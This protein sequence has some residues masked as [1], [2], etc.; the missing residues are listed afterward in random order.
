MAKEACDK[1][2]V[3]VVM[4]R[5]DAA[6]EGGALFSE[7]AEA[8]AGKAPTM[9][10]PDPDDLAVIMYTSGTTGNPKGVMQTHRNIC[11]M[12][13]GQE[14]QGVMMGEIM[15]RL[16]APP[17][18]HEPCALLPVPLFHVVALHHVFLA[19]VT[20]GQKLVMMRRWDAKKALEHIQNEKVVR[21]VG[22][23]TMVTD[24]MEHPEF[25]S[26]DTS[27]LS[28]MVSGG[29]PT[30]KSQV[31]RTKEALPSVGGTGTGQGYGLTETN[32]GVC[33]NVGNDYVT[34]PTSTGKPS[35]WVE[36]EIREVEKRTTDPQ[37]QLIARAE[38]DGNDKEE[39]STTSA[40]LFKLIEKDGTGEIAAVEWQRIFP[41]IDEKN[42]AA[43]SKSE[44]AA[45]FMTFKPWAKALPA[46][47]Q[48][49]AY[50]RSPTNMPGY[51]NKPEQ[52]AEVLDAEGWFASGDIAMLDD[53]GCLYI[54]DR[55][56]DLIIRGG[57]NISCVEVEAAH[58]A[59]LSVL[60]P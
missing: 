15:K 21:F 51:F 25:A 60:E 11:V 4:V 27:S 41:K 57:E 50:I 36:L 7:S 39:A 20:S 42:L 58:P 16:G 45:F 30:P 37:G 2:G 18:K 40:T 52:T 48:G 56:K 6:P 1:L 31:G 29:G 13:H 8:G 59:V 43:V 5:G 47:T 46:N 53:D 12:M 38:A 26:F 35:P 49:E 3:K 44:R 34:H 23:P 9:S 19:S 10:I 22:V 14:L 28:V 17:P 55:A 32:G 54:M 24:M 33:A